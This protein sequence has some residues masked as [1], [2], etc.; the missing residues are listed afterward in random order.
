M[1]NEATQYTVVDRGVL[2]GLVQSLKQI[3]VRGYDSMDRL[4]GC[5]M[6]LENLMN[7]P[8]PAK[9]EEQKEESKEE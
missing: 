4:V 2:Y 6:V 3:D 7:A 5:V 9:K 8:A 1:G